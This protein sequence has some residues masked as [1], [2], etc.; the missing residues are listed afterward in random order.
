MLAIEEE[1]RP[2]GQNYV[3]TFIE[4]ELKAEHIVECHRKENDK[5]TQIM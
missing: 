1:I 4:T 5:D 3:K 2:Y